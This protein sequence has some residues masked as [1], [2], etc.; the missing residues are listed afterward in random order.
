MR[1]ATALY[2]I[3][4]VINVYAQFVDDAMINQFTKP[5][6]MPIL[7]YLVFVKADGFVNL[8]RLL[9]SLA[10]IFAWVG[11]MLLLVKG[12][13]LFFLGGLGSFLVMQLLYT[14]VFHKSMDNPY[15]PKNNVIVP[16][17]IGFVAIA[18]ASYMYAGEMW[19]P[20]TIYALC[21]LTM[22]VFALNRNGETNSKSFL[23][24]TLGAG[25]FVISD[26]LIGI[27]KFMADVPYA[28]FLIML[29][30]IPAQYLIMQG[31]MIHE[32]N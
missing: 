17:I 19:L 21:I 30:Y 15:M 5:V 11:D 9:L 16:A 31:V 4:G 23:M 6:L 20:V 12:D 32:K 29:T 18:Y 13:E 26:S 22:L 27:D 8:A 10:L 3:V 7:I 1:L 28:P 2:L 24:T 25:L 14:V